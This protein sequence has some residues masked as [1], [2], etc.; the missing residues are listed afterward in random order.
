MLNSS[1]NLNFISNL[2][3]TNV[4]FS[5]F[6]FKVLMAKLRFHGIALSS[7]IIYLNYDNVNI[8]TIISSVIKVVT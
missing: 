8:V 7:F 4:S 6:L 3:E 1:D 2:R 5:I